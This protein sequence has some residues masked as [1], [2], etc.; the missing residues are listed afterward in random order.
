MEKK[1]TRDGYGEALLELGRSHENIVV[2]DADLSGSTKTN[3][4]AKEFPE[5]FFNVGVAEQ[6]LVGV[7]AG[8]ALSGMVPFASSFA[9][10]LAGRA[11]E[12]VR[13]SIAYPGLNAKLVATHA[14]LTVGEDGASHQI[15]EDIGLMRVIPDMQVFVPSDYEETMQ[16]IR[17]AYAI[18]GPCYVRCGRSATPV[19]ARKSSYSFR[20]GRGEVRREGKDVTIVACG[21]MVHEADEAANLLKEKGI[22][23]AVVNM[24]SIK[25]IDEALLKRLAKKTG[26][27]VT[28]EE[29][30]IV[31]G[32]GSAV[33]EV[34]S[35]T[36][37]VPVIR[38][39]VDDRFGQSGDA[40]E[41]LKHY[42][43]TAAN[44]AK[45]AQRAI[46]LKAG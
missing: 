12:I 45:Q 36:A 42:G 4:F 28:A 38:V 21:V 17:R 26:A 25:P 10:F 34:L 30:N 44:I 32:L 40:Y 1:A 18:K 15:I 19:L 3:R 37:P 7:T 29:H 39:G 9:M 20:E 23:A 8:F 11:W 46:K 5:R 35:A 2:L 43:L 31:G 33:A 22:S 16:I 6:N 13:N 24:A 14:G 27:M 41:L